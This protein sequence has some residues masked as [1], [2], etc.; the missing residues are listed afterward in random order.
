VS[1]A[2]Y[3]RNLRANFRGCWSGV[4]GFDEF[5]YLMT[6]TVRHGL[7]Q[8]FNAGMKKAGI[9]SFAINPEEKLELQNMIFTETNHIG[10]VAAWLDQNKKADGTKLA[11]ILRRADGW[12]AR[13]GEA[14]ALGY[15]LGLKDEPQEWFLGATEKH[16]HDCS[17]YNGRVYRA[18]VWAKHGIRPKSTKLS[19]FGIHCD[20]KLDKTDKK[21]NRG[22]PPKPTGKG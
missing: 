13:W 14:N 2:D 8:A 22:R 20:C 11:T 10:N 18:S 1:S 17:T 5:V 15:Q 3:R 6:I 21:L 9:E 7:T 4:F 16:C 12:V 19:C